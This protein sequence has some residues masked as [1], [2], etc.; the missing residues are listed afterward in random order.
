MRLPGGRSETF[1]FLA[2]LGYE[3]FFFYQRELIPISAYVDT[4]HKLTNFLIQNYVFVHPQV[5]QLTGR[6]PPYAVT[7]PGTAQSKY[8]PAPQ[9]SRSAA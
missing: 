3:G 4:V 1:E 8:P 5:V 6:K 2:E 7:R 9:P